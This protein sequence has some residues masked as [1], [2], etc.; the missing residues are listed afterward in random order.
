MEQNSSPSSV[1]F[2]SSL[3]GHLLVATPQMTDERFQH[4]AIFMCQHD[5]KAAMGLI[6]NQ[7][8][9]EYSLHHLTEKLEID[10]PRFQPDDPIYI[11]GPVEPQRGYILH[12]DDQMMPDSIPVTEQICL[13]LHVDMISEI[14]QGIGPVFSKI[15]LGYAGWAA[16]QLEAELKENMWFHLP[17]TSEMVFATDDSDIWAKSFNRLGITAGSLSSQSGTA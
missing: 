1:P 5:D 3:A 10:A 4:K 7:P 12:S 6:I 15:M 13:C 9:S 17:A 16:G 2:S 11:G 8:S 14:S